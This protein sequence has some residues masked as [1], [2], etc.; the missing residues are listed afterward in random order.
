MCSA[1]PG[2]TPAI[3]LTELRAQFERALSKHLA[4]GRTGPLE[5]FEGLIAWMDRHGS[6][7]AR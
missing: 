4:A 3:V 1:Y 2:M 5:V 7:I 6:T